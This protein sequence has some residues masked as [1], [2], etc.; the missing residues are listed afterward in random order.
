MDE[1]SFRKGVLSLPISTNS[2]IVLRDYALSH[3][4]T[5]VFIK[6]MRDYIKECP[7]FEVNQLMTAAGLVL[8]DSSFHELNDTVFQCCHYF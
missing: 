7:L 2:W 1:E 4:D 5:E 6:L 8:D 3:A